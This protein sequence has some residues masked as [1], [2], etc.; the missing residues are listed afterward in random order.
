MENNIGDKITIK[1]IDALMGFASNEKKGYNIIINN[2]L[3]YINNE[4]Y[5]G[6]LDYSIECIEFISSNKKTPKGLFFAEMKEIIQSEVGKYIDKIDEIK[7]QIL[8]KK[9][10]SETFPK[11]TPDNKNN[12]NLETFFRTLDEYKGKYEIKE[13]KKFDGGR[14]NFNIKGTIELIEFSDVKV[15][16]NKATKVLLTHFED[17]ASQFFMTD[18]KNLI[19]DQNLSIGDVVEVNFV[20]NCVK[21]S[22]NIWFNNFIIKSINKA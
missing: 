11:I 19:K 10:P 1:R 8:L 20:I 12:I 9:T 17:K 21:S 3:C 2:N 14:A 15:G 5:N 16:F 18:I 7:D 6:L 4:H 22:K 13:S